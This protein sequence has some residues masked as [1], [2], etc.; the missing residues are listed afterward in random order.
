MIV[1]AGIERVVFFGDAPEGWA[2]DVL[3][4][5]GVLVCGLPEPPRRSDAG[6]DKLILQ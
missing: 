4:H 3:L 5:G 1:G 2:S 6:W